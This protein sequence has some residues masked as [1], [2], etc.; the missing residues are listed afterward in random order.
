MGWELGSHQALN[1]KMP[2]EKKYVNFKNSLLATE[3]KPTVHL[4]VA[5]R[6]VGISVITVLVLLWGM[7]LKSHCL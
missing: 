3:S 6:G 5:G 2:L 4:G 7:S 1:L